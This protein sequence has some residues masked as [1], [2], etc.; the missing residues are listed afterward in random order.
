MSLS[1]PFPV[2]SPEAEVYE[3][4]EGPIDPDSGYARAM[5][6][7]ATSSA[8]DMRQMQP[9]Y[10]I[11][12]ATEADIVAVI[13]YARDA[14]VSVAVRSGGHAYH[15][16]SSTGGNNIQL[17]TTRCAA[18]KVWRFDEKAQQLT[19]GTG[20]R[21]GQVE[22]NMQSNYKGLA[23]K[24]YF[25]AHG[26][27]ATVGVGGHLH[28]GGYA[29]QSRS[30][31][32]FIDYVERFRIITADGV[33]REV[34]RPNPTAPDPDNDD[35]WFSV[36]G[37][38]PGNFGVCT[39]VTVRLLHDRQFP[40]SRAYMQSYLWTRKNGT[41]LIEALLGHMAR[42][43]D[44]GDLPAD[45]CFHVALASAA[46][47]YLTWG[48]IFR[49]LLTTLSAVLEQLLLKVERRTSNRF[50]AT[51][52]SLSLRLFRKAFGSSG[53][54]NPLFEA[55]VAPVII[56]QASWNNLS[57]D[58]QDY[59]ENVKA[60]FREL[61]ELALPYLPQGF[62]GRLLQKSMKVVNP[63][64]HLPVTEIIDA[65]TF[66][67]DREFDLPY[68][69]RNWAGYETDLT[70]R[71]FARESALL[72]EPFTH[73]IFSKADAPWSG[74]VVVCAWGYLGG[75]ESSVVRNA[76]TTRSAMPHRNSGIAWMTDYFYDPDIEG[77]HE[78]LNAWVAQ[79]DR[80]VVG[81]KDAFF[82]ERDARYMFDP[83]DVFRND[84]KRVPPDLDALHD[85]FYDSEEVYQRVLRTKQ[86]FDPQGLFSA[87][88]FSVGGSLSSQEKSPA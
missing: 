6:Q 71:G 17:D 11:Y 45:F 35:L 53:G 23:T 64:K 5:R 48:K 44:R 14:G 12:P 10:V 60:Y 36:L 57:G 51:C 4:P 82:S 85:H 21:L 40:A 38:G 73:S 46:P 61:D 28:T 29:M 68:I 67:G 88:H 24:G 20:W 43:N 32:L 87:N 37:G 22:R 15:G 27:C 62:A 47:K 31:G 25:F 76:E 3:R 7:Y 50:S 2:L 65:F 13:R 63:D 75:S 34:R 8:P 26:N 49:D 54:R 52:A 19:F 72:F 16:G 58:A 69:K 1:T 80:R 74:N 33:V 79:Y 59:G 56:V 70:Q 78:R 83:F 66:K 77:A 84:T 81:S 55:S 30:F 42:I 41:K 18:C 39:E 86:R 9:A